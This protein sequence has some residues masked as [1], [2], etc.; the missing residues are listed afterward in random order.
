[1]NTR[2]AI[3]LVLIACCASCDFSK[4]DHS[5]VQLS[6]PASIPDVRPAIIDP[7]IPQQIDELTAQLAGR[8]VLFIGESHDRLE[9]HRNQLRI[10]KSLYARYPD[11]A[12]G[13]EYFQQPFQ[14]YLDDYIAGRIT[15]REM[16]VGTEY[17]KRWKLDYRMLQPI[18][19]F[20]LENHIPLLA[21]SISDEIH[22]KVFRGG[23]K[24]LSPLELAQIPADM[25]PASEGYLQR[26][27]SIF[28]SHPANDDFGAFV[29][30]VL[31]WD[32]SMA[33]TAARYLKTHPGTRMVVLAGMVHVMYGD[34]IPG[35]VNRRMGS[36]QSVVVINGNDFGSYPGIADFQLLVKNGAALPK[37]GKLGVAIADGSHGVLIS[38]FAIASAARAAGLVAGDRIVAVNGVEVANISELES[39]LFDKPPGERIR[40]MVQRGGRTDPVQELSFEV[41]LR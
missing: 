33:D 34:G 28:I 40:L 9:H 3:I 2:L 35:R 16:L 10:I 11:F 20:A 39:I 21:L 25:Q 32:E 13:V 6:A 18:F 23:M 17:F 14:S 5:N 7:D 22:S 30:G 1:M 24:S 29:E 15:E 12:I 38:D 27:K 4:H 26:M 31:L 36:N 19:Q 8:R 37:A 41:A